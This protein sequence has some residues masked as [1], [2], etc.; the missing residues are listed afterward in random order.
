MPEE[1]LNDPSKAQIESIILSKAQRPDETVSLQNSGAPARILAAITSLEARATVRYGRATYDVHVSGNRPLRAA[2]G[3]WL[4]RNILGPLKD[5]LRNP[6]AYPRP[7]EDPQ[8]QTL[9]DHLCQLILGGCNK[10]ICPIISNAKNYSDQV[11]LIEPPG[12]MTGETLV[13]Y[14]MTVWLDHRLYEEL[15]EV[16]P[17]GGGYD[18]RFF[19]ANEPSRGFDFVHNADGFVDHNWTNRPDREYPVDPQFRAWI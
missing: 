17:N 6:R 14:P 1:I 9:M 2:T 12:G 16:V 4:E 5:I 13:P 8:F 15:A 7:A 10:W 19:R 18:V 3:S 11:Q